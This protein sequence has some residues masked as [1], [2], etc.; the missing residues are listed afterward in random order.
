TP[1]F[2]SHA[3][4]NMKTRADLLASFDKGMDQL[5][6]DVATTTEEEWE[7]G[8]SVLDMGPNGKWEDTKYAM[9]WGFLFDAIHHRGQLSTFLR[10]MGAKVP[11]IYG[12]SADSK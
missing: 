1:D 9:A 10:Q 6:K 5:K 4:G 12:P 2:N 3:M 7:N 11:S 8:K